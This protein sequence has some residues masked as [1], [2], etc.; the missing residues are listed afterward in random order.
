M[1]LS[2]NNAAL[3]SRPLREQLVDY[4]RPPHSNNEPHHIDKPDEVRDADLIELFNTDIL[5]KW[6]QQYKLSDTS[7]KALQFTVNN[8]LDDKNMLR[9]GCALGNEAAVAIEDSMKQWK[10]PKWLSNTLYYG[11]WAAAIASSGARVVLRGLGTGN[12][13]TFFET[14]VQDIV[15][16]F[17]G[18]TGIIMVADRAQNW[19]YKNIKL[20]QSIINFIRPMISVFLAEKSIVSILDPVGISLGRILTGV[21]SPEKYKK[22]SESIGNKL[23]AMLGT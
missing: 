7:L 8:F 17:I 12:I 14:A 11:L 23:K 13:K 2:P 4:S 3:D 1:E 6:Q 18:P 10:F 5:P 20:P 19:I 9:I 15:A 21:I 16:A 22:W